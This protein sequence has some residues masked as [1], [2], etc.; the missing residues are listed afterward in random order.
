MSILQITYLTYQNIITIKED[1]YSVHHLGMKI[2]FKEEKYDIKDLK[3]ANRKT[4]Q[5]YRLYI[6]M[7][8]LW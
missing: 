2:K 4:G 5:L 7:I 6:L 8:Y 3:Y 1:V